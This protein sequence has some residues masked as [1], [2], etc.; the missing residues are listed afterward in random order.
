[1]VDEGPAD[2][3]FGFICCGVVIW[4]LLEMKKIL[5]KHSHQTKQEFAE[6]LGWIRQANLGLPKEA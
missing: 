5:I 4:N 1:M 3:N 6:Q 2:K